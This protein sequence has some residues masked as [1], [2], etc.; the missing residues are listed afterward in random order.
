[1]PFYIYI[2]RALILATELIRP[3]LIHGEVCAVRLSLIYT[4][5]IS[6]TQRDM[7][8]PELWS[9]I[10]TMPPPPPRPTGATQKEAAHVTEILTS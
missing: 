9:N 2:E 7:Y 6:S 3:V 10:Y 5:M 8:F 1:M 4:E